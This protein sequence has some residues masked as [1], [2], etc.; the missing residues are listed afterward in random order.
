M[1]LLALRRVR[2]ESA[3]Q[4]EKGSTHKEWSL[5]D[6]AEAKSKVVANDEGGGFR[7][8]PGGPKLRE[9]DSAQVRCRETG[10]EGGGFGGGHQRQ[11]E[12][13]RL[14]HVPQCMAGHVSHAPGAGKVSSAAQ[15]IRGSA[16]G[17]AEPRSAVDSPRKTCGG[18][19]GGHTRRRQTVKWERVENDSRG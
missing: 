3:G 18:P 9:E 11:V 4:K 19:E 7:H 1:G 6:R 15:I 14:P 12:Y 16:R 5:N 13:G 8:P 17:R 2:G 10:T